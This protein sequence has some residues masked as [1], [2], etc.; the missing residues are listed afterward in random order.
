MDTRAEH[1]ILRY[2]EREWRSLSPDMQPWGMWLTLHGPLPEAADKL[3]RE[4][5][6]ARQAW[7]LD[8]NGLR[9]RSVWEYRRFW[10]VHFLQP[11]CSWAFGEPDT[12]FT[13]R[14]HAI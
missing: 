2:I 3:D 11:W 6:P 12:M 4:S 5:S 14:R 1:T 8:E 10:A 13:S 7:F 9:P